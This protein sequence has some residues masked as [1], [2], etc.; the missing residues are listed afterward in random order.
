[1]VC[2]QGGVA[3]VPNPTH[4]VGCACQF[5]RKKI[6]ALPSKECYDLNAVFTMDLFTE[7]VE[8]SCVMQ[9]PWYTNAN[10]TALEKTTL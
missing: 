7:F 6:I 10:K 1:M 8:K 5:Q 4:A 3:Y 2:I 9:I